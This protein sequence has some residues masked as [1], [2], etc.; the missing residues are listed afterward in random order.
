MR[1]HAEIAKEKIE[2]DQLLKN[3]VQNVH[4]NFVNERDFEGEDNVQKYKKFVNDYIAYKYEPLVEDYEEARYFVYDFE[5][6]MMRK[7]YWKF[8]RKIK[9]I[10]IK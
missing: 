3:L 2:E 10:S 9:S 4:G 7:L 8:G 1:A 6:Q 5:G